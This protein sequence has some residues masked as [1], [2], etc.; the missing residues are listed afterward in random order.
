MQAVLEGDVA[1]LVESSELTV[2]V[3]GFRGTEGPVWHPAA[4]CLTFVDLEGNQLLRWSRGDGVQILRDPNSQGNGC[5]LDGTG[6]LVMCEGG[7][8]SIVRMESDGS[9]TTLADRYLGKRLNRPNDII[10]RSDGTYFFTDPNLFVAK[11]ERDFEHSMVWRLSPDGDL[12]IVATELGFPNG[13]ALSPDESVLYV[14]N[15]F[16]DERCIE[17]RKRKE[18]CPH[19]YLAAYDVGADG[20]LANF[21]RITDLSSNAHDVPDGLKVDVNGIVYLTGSGAVWVMDPQG[22][23]LG[24]IRT[25]EPGRNCAFGDADMRTLY[26]ASLTTVYSLRMVHPGISGTGERVPLAR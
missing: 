20:S 24:K 6:R 22:N 7:S 11:D 8:R 13:L 4:G 9:W 1:G 19:R 21:R 18:V 14:A 5:T 23:V 17:E 15:S 3:Q 16:L 12:A 25:P 26:I 10:R 2:I